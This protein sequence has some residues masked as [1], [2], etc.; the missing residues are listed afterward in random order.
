[1][2]WRRFGL[3]FVSCIWVPQFVVFAANTEPAPIVLQPSLYW[4]VLRF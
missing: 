1:M 3:A 4:Y 2:N